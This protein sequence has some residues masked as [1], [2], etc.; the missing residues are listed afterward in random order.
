VKV[1]PSFDGQFIFAQQFKRSGDVDC[2]AAC[3]YLPNPP[4]QC[5]CEFL[6]VSSN[7]NTFSFF[8]MGDSYMLLGFPMQIHAETFQILER[9]NHIPILSKEPQLQ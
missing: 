9:T 3:K 2:A 4:V 6:R 8:H 7:F 5:D 1:V